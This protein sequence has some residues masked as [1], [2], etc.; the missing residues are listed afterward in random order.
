MKQLLLP[1]LGLLLL[2]QCKKDEP[3]LASQL[4]PATQTG[5][6]TF[7]CL[8]NGQP[9]TPTYNFGIGTPPPLRV[10]Y[11]PT[12]A[13]GSLQIRAIR[14]VTGLPDGQYL[15]LDG[16]SLNKAGTYPISIAGPA[17][18]SYS[19]GLRSGPCQEYYYANKAPGFFMQGQLVITRLDMSAG[20][21]AGTF[22]FTLA[23]TG[24]DTIKVTQGR[25]DKKL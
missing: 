15:F 11:D 2:T 23:Q 24:C 14:L 4:P 5:A 22:S 1:A 16:A 17:G 10:T 7:G 12:Y 18:V 21:I 25:F 9:W 3:D 8:L 13:G 6:N 19:T 20:I